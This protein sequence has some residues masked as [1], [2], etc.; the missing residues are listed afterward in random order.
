LA[1]KETLLAEFTIDELKRLAEEHDVPLVKKRSLLGVFNVTRTVTQKTD[2][3]DTLAN[4]RVT[5]EQIQ[6]FTE[7]K[8]GPSQA[9]SGEPRQPQ[10][11]SP[12]QVLTRLRKPQLVG[13]CDELWIPSRGYKAALVDQLIPRL[14]HDPR[15]A[16]RVLTK[17]YRVR[18]L[19][20]LLKRHYLP[21]TGRKTQLV[22]DVMEH[23]E[24]GERWE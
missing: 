24:L 3:I 18:D 16:Q 20:A 12:R 7:R 6:R 4:S 19:K 11:I 2:I 23:L 9:P 1:S 17:Y 15:L 14:R 22:V 21:F 10:R 13:L 8:T 5:A